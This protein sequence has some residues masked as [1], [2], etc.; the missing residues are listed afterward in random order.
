[1]TDRRRRQAPPPDVEAGW[2]EPPIYA[3]DRRR[4]IHAFDWGALAA[5]VFAVI[6]GLLWAVLDLHLGLIAV[7]VMGGWLIGGA[8]S[9]GAWRGALHI[10]SN[11]LRLLGGVL[12]GLAWLGGTAV[13]YLVSQA[14]I[15]SPATTFAERVSFAGFAEYL[16][17]VSDLV[18]GIAAV[19]LVFFSWRSAR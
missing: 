3:L 7:A 16:L 13:S 2:P 11:R 19:T 5:I 14:L 9:H 18:Q 6:Y 15:Q 4:A 12:G 17:G 8:V 1:M 10:P